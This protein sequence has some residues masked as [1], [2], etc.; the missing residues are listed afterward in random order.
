MTP[1][2]IVLALFLWVASPRTDLCP[3][4][5]FSQCYVGDIKALWTS[6]DFVNPSGVQEHL[7][8]PH[9][10][11]APEA[12]L[13]PSVRD[14]FSTGLSGSFSVPTWGHPYLLCC[15]LA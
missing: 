2:T 6:S 12:S 1:S 14:A 9:H 3:R 11:Q 8:S 7:Y 13:R 5:C 10:D 4:E 15:T